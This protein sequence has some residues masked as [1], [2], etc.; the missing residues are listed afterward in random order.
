MTLRRLAYLVVALLVGA[1][2]AGVTVHYRGQLHQERERREIA[3]RLAELLASRADSVAREAARRADSTA[4]AQSAALAEIQREQRRLA[5][6]LARYR[7]EIPLPDPATPGDTVRYWREVAT[8]ALQ[9]VEKLRGERALS[10]SLHGLH[11]GT[12]ARLTAERDSAWSRVDALVDGV[13]RLRVD[14]E[15]VSRQQMRCTIP[16]TGGRLS[17]GT[18]IGVALGTYLVV[19]REQ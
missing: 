19:R 13:D 9:E 12:I 17:C 7:A 4:R 8:T 1:S 11:I 18:A 5:D 15:R 14:L 16:L 10:D 2:I 6:S 3:E